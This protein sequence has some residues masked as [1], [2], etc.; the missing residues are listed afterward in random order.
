MPTKLGAILADLPITSLWAG[1][2]LSDPP[3]VPLG[4][5]Q[6]GFAGPV[7]LWLVGTSLMCLSLTS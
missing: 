4:K 7:R 5:S 1:F 3:K 2:L 6:S